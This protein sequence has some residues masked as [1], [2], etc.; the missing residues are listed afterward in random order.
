V[1]RRLANQ[2]LLAATRAYDSGRTD[3]VPVDE[4]IAFAFDC[5]PAAS[6]LNCYRSLQLRRRIGPTVMPYLKPLNLYAP[7][8]RAKEGMALVHW[9]LLGV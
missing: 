1:R 5:W 2:A 7:V 8:R 3:Q 4:L 6:S 9:R